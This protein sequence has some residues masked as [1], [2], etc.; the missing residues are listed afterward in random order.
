M[1]AI[2]VIPGKKDTVSLIDVETPAIKYGQVLVRNIRSGV[3]AT[4]REINDGLYGQAPSG[5]DYLVLGHESH[6][7]VEKVAKGVNSLKP[8]D[9]VVRAVR[10]PCDSCLPCISGSNDLCTSGGFIESG[11]KELSGCMSEYWV[12]TEQFLYKIPQEQK[13]VAVLLEPLSV[14]EKALRLSVKFREG[15][16]WHPKTSMVIGAGPIGLLQAMLCRNRN[17]ETYVIARSP[18]G[19]RKSQLVESIGAH[20]LSTKETPFHDIQVQIGKVD[21][22]VEASGDSRMA[23][24]SMHALANNGVLCL[25]S[26]TGGQ[27]RHDV[28]S[29]K[30]N[31]DIVLGNKLI[32]G[33]VNANWRDYAAGVTDLRRFMDR[34]PDVLPSLFTKRI[35]LSDFRDAFASDSKDIKATIE[36]SY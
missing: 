28:A 19:N 22:I 31:L 11:I 7:V 6:G 33:T 27:A 9:H 1:K 17:M 26:I 30:L 14:V 25:T 2:A 23:F 12:D 16:Y 36:F 8:G 24:D 15:Q 32:F 10:R 35:A 3:C 18:G 29:D 4:D 21:L 13:D 5:L 20:Y 34:W